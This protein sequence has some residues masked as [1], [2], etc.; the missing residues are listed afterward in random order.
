MFTLYKAT[1]SLALAVEH[2]RHPQSKFDGK[3]LLG[4]RPKHKQVSKQKALFQG[5]T[6]SDKSDT[7]HFSRGTM[8]IKLLALNPCPVHDSLR[9]EDWRQSGYATWTAASVLPLK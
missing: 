8:P 2:G 4:P 3:Q 6:C 9:D 5:R 1:M 7:C